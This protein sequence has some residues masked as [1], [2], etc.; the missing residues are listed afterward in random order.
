MSE[1][2]MVCTNEVGH[3]SVLK[4]CINTIDEVPLRRRAYRVSVEKEQFIDKEIKE[5]LANNM[6]RPSN[7]PWASPVVIVPKNDSGSRFCVD[8]RGMN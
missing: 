4:H 7:S 2:P 5:M 3:S 8:F 6:I 1:W